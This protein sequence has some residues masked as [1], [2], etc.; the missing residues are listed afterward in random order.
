MAVD[1]C[2]ECGFVPAA[3]DRRELPDQV[4]RHAAA[5]GDRLAGTDPVRLRARRAGLAWSALEY[6]G[7]IG[8]VL[9]LFDRRV[10]RIR[11]AEGADLE[12]VD[13]DS[14]VAEQR[15]RDREPA[16]LAARV[17]AAAGRLAA[18]L[19]ATP[20]ADWARA[21]RRAGQ[22]RTIDDIARRAL[23]EQIHH[24]HDV[25]RLISGHRSG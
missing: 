13:H 22:V 16:E 8:D 4:R 11:A 9:E 6:A 7:H 2:D 20:A 1:P 23:H 18:T 14:R 10:V 15:Y 19:A 12:V 17:A 21:G 25:D 5:L 24:L 3:V